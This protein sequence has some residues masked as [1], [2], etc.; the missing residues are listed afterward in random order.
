MDTSLLTGWLSWLVLGLGVAGSVFLLARRERWW[1]L[2]VVPAVVVVAGVAAWLLGTIV[3]ERLF[4]APLTTSDIVWIAVALAA[5]PL[6]VGQLF[7]TP[8]WRK[9]VAVVAAIAV[10]AA[11]GNQI[12]K[13]Y[14]E[15][16]AVK[17][18]FGPSGTDEQAALPGRTPKSTPTVQTTEPLTTSW[19]PTG[20]GIPTD[21]KGKV[22]PFDIPNTQSGFSARPAWVYLPPAYFADNRTPLPVVILYHGQPGSPDEWIFGDRVQSTMNAFAAQHNGIAPI[23]VMPDVLGSQLANPICADSALGNVDT[24]LAK[25]VPAAITTQLDVDPDPK[26]WVVGGFSYGGTC[27]LQMATN[28]PDRFPNFIDISG[29]KEPTR[30]SGDTARQTTVADAF[31]GDESKFIAINPADLMQK[32]KYPHSAGWF[33]WGQNDP[34]YRSDQ[35]HNYKLAKAAGMAVQTWESPGTAHDWATATA[36]LDHTMPWIAST[37]GL[38]S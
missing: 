27:S 3:A 9:G 17:D 31:G 6:A 14:Q 10:I 30:G 26:H 20:S 22:L 23:V 13:N 38:T 8:W 35:L 18:L 5:V 33:V 34:D 2:Y 29:E 21:G 7:R 32:N 15:F 12:N 25:D 11:A 36:A 24:Y 28:H 16:P 4:A 19:I 1:W 37:T